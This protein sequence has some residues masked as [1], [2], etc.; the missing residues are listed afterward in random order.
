MAQNWS[1]SYEGRRVMMREKWGPSNQGWIMA[2]RKEMKRIR[3]GLF[4]QYPS[5]STRL[6]SSIRINVCSTLFYDSS[7]ADKKHDS[8]SDFFFLFSCNLQTFFSS[9]VYWFVSLINGNTSTFQTRWMLVTR[10]AFM[11]TG[12]VMVAILISLVWLVKFG[13]RFPCML[14]S[15]S[16]PL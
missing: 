10:F 14:C 2:K 9:P 15:V 11:R 6:P 1:S 7:L 16:C 8:Q 3:I 12:K 4:Q 13:P 5:R